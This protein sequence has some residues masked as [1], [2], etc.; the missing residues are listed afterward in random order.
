[1][2]ESLSPLHPLGH[3][4]QG[5]G[6]SAS[7]SPT[8]FNSRALCSTLRPLLHH[9]LGIW[10]LVQSGMGLLYWAVSLDQACLLGPLVPKADHHTGVSTPALGSLDKPDSQKAVAWAWWLQKVSYD[11]DQNL[12][13]GQVC[14]AGP[15][16]VSVPGP[17]SARCQVCDFSRFGVFLPFL[18]GCVSVQGDVHCAEGPWMC[19]HVC[20][21]WGVLGR[22]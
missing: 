11:V 19:V 9:V 8:G 6:A 13:Q 12:P 21:C 20:V 18:W 2:G 22:G 16:L 4:E 17:P 7:V 1:M 10:D 14:R 5:R 3:R 15:P